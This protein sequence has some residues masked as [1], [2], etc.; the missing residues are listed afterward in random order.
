MQVQYKQNNHVRT[1]YVTLN[2]VAEVLQLLTRLN[3]KILKVREC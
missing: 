2:K 3:H 1:I